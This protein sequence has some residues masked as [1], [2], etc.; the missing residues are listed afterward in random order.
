M[1]TQK[2]GYKENIKRALL[3]IIAIIISSSSTFGSIALAYDSFYSNNDILFY[4]PNSQEASGDDNNCVSSGSITSKIWNY[5][6][7]KGLNEIQ[8]AGIIGNLMQESDISPT[9]WQTINTTDKTSNENILTNNGSSAHAWGIAQWDGTRRYDSS[10]NSDGTI[11]ESGV[12]GALIKNK[13][14]LVKYLNSSY[15]SG[16]AVMTG[17]NDTGFVLTDENPLASKNIPEADLN[18][19]LMFELD[20]IWQEFPGNGQDK[21]MANSSTII[22]AA[23]TFNQYFEG[24]GDLATYGLEWIKARRGGYG[25]AVYNK[26]HGSSSSSGCSSGNQLIDTIKKY[27]WPTHKG[28]YDNSNVSADK[29]TGIVAVTPTVDYA[30]AILKAT[31]EGRYD[32]DECTN[33]GV[34]SGI[35]CGAFVTTFIY[36]SGWDVNYNYSGKGGNTTSQKTWLDANWQNLGEASTIDVGILKPGDVSINAYG[37]DAHTFVYIGDVDG[38][39]TNVA[40]ASQCQRA[41]M[42]GSESLTGTGYTWYRKK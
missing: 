22:D 19:L 25:Q 32:G 10:T 23:V 27:V 29:R 24:S 6:I 13:P 38:Y 28:W 3:I 8:T 37:N 42:A 11:S 18:E 34:G 31:S 21:F 9:A 17:T 20:Y 7:Q 39:E 14:L 15:S 36:D 4:D 2:T 40:S 12:I 5:F 33:L 30:N 26:L 16:G 1:I 41:P 35:D